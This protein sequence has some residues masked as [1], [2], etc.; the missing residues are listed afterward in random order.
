LRP[1][2]QKHNELDSK[3]ILSR[4][5]PTLG[6]LLSVEDS[7]LARRGAAANLQ[8][9]CRFPPR[10][11]GTCLH[12]TRTEF[13][14]TSNAEATPTQSLKTPSSLPTS[15]TPPPNGFS[16]PPQRPPHAL[17]RPPPS[18]AAGAS[19]VP[20]HAVERA[21]LRFDIT[22][23]LARVFWKLLG[24]SREKSVA[25]PA[26]TPFSPDSSVHTHKWARAPATFD[27]AATIF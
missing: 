15:R 25:C 27:K 26:S 18:C 17:P 19:D 3:M 11:P 24:D 20:V 14:K 16:R 1:N 21:R 7:T 13:Q 10:N 5:P 23:D 12:K 6:R 9:N 4:R 2:L 22:C 8:S